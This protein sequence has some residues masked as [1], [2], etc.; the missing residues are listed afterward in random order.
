MDSRLDYYSF[1][2]DPSLAVAP[3]KPKSA[4]VSGLDAKDRSRYLKMHPHAVLPEYDAT[5]Y[6]DGNLEIVGDVHGIAT[7]ALRLPLDVFLYDH[8]QRKC[9]YAEAA[10]CVHSSHDW[11]WRIAAQM[12]AYRREGYPVDNGLFDGSVII[13]RNTPAC[14]RLMEAWWAEYLGGLKRDQVS[15]PVVAWRLGI[16]IGSL[17]T[18]DRFF[19]QKFFVPRG[20]RSGAGFGVR[21]RKYLNRGVAAGLSY[22]RLFSLPASFRWR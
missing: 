3:W 14:R 22:G 11:V 18:N 9:A 19:A 10:A 20:H 16:D 17:G 15:L 5:I 12:R 6:V 13:R 21:L 4:G 8:F 2:D 1:I 7:A